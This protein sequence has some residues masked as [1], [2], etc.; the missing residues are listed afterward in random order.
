MDN[1]MRRA[2]REA[3]LG[4][5][6]AAAVLKRM[7]ERLRMVEPMAIVID[8]ET[9]DVTEIREIG[10]GDLREIET[11]QGE[12]FIVSESSETAGAAARERWQDM[13]ENDAEEFA[14]IVG[15]QTLVSWALG[16]SAGPGTVHVH[17]LSEWLDLVADHPDE[18]WAGY[19]GA[20]REVTLCGADLAEELGF[21]PGAAY[22]TN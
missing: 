16:R 19:D 18:E 3:K 4:D 21:T 5:A 9:Y 8:G 17:S 7:R 14:A 22:R 10:Y 6:G 15:E 20:E 2:E 13:A 11:D 12:D 1:E